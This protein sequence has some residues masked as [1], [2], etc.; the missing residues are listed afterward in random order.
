MVYYIPAASPSQVSTLEL[1]LHIWHDEPES[2]IQ[3]VS[4]NLDTFSH[5]PKTLAFT[6]STNLS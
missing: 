3:H 2:P 4:S 1:F 5:Q 6:R